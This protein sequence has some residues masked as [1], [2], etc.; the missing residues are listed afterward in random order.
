VHWI[1]GQVVQVFWI[2]HEC[3]NCQYC[4]PIFKFE[5][6]NLVFESVLLYFQK[7]LTDLV[8]NNFTDLH[9]ILSDV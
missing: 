5:I 7:V 3:A 8:I 1:L 4:Q 6:S 9:E 2:A